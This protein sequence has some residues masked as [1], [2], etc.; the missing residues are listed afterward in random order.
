MACAPPTS[1]KYSRKTG[2]G[3]NQWPSP[4]ITGCFKLAC[5]SVAR[6]IIVTAPLPCRFLYNRLA[7]EPSN[8]SECEVTLGVRHD[9]GYLEESAF[10]PEP[11]RDYAIHFGRRAP[12]R[13]RQKKNTIG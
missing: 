1:H 2:T 3:S 4:S 10:R 6:L 9:I 7:A 5:I 8:V 11:S 13:L 12:A